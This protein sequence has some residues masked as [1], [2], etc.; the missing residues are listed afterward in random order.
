MCELTLPLVTQKSERKIA[1]V[2]LFYSDSRY[3]PGL[4]QAVLRQRHP[5]II[6][7]FD[8]LDVF[9]VDNGSEDDTYPVMCD[10]W[11]R[12]GTPE[13]IHL[14]HH[15]LNLGIAGALNDA[16]TRITTPFVL[17]CHCDAIFESDDYAATMA[18]LLE[19]YPRAGAIAGQPTVP[20]KQRIPFAEKVNLITNL[21]DIP[22]THA[23]AELLAPVGFVEGR[24][25]AFRLAA[26]QAAGFYDT[27]LQLAGEDQVLAARMRAAGYELYQCPKLTYV[28]SVS[29]DQNTLCKLARHQRLFGR[30]HPYIVLMNRGT[31]AG[32]IGPPAGPNRQ[33]R[34]LLR[35]LQLIST[36]CYLVASV[37]FL[38]GLPTVMV[39]TP[40]ASVLIA[41]V[42]LFSRHLRAIPLSPFHFAGLL[43]CQPFLDLNYTWGVLQGLFLLKKGSATRSIR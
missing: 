10:E 40:L 25:D 11:A 35:L 13:H 17:T 4:F 5:T 1:I 29:N 32:V 26:L 30:A 24:C 39:I 27:T 6:N 41:K 16:F 18:E 21:M 7:Q 38:R 33:R 36:A 15:S 3:V 34:A 19:S 22:T 28:L 12:A 8:W 2:I 14:I 42:I 9:F 20:T 23:G 31:S 37:S 43:L